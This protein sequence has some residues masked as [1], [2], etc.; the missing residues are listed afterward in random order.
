M[1]WLTFLLVNVGLHHLVRQIPRAD[2]KIAPCPKVAP[3]KHPFQMCEL[4]KEYAGADPFEPLHD[5]AYVNVR[6][7]RHQHL[8][9]VAC[10]FSR[11]DRDLM[12]HCDLPD[13]VAYAQCN[14]PGQNLFPILWYPNK[15]YL[16]IVFRVC[17]KLV[18]F[19]GSTL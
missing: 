9:V 1:H 2:G 13:Q 4:L 6:S 14:L 19:H 10:H 18:S 3:P 11:Q 5:H 8:D 17:A 7:V 15:M 16:Q 12:L